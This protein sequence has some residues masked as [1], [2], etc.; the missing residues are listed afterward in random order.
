MN[1]AALSGQTSSLQEPGRKISG[2]KNII[3][4]RFPE[5]PAKS[6]IS[7]KPMREKISRTIS[8]SSLP[9][10]LDLAITETI[11]QVIVH[12]SDGLHVGINDSRTN[13]TESA[14][15]QVLAECI[16]FG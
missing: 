9:I 16:G 10:L 1:L 4:N 8:R 6:M 11:D 3:P 5:N 14:M 7:G 12:H 2:I 13:E 15:L